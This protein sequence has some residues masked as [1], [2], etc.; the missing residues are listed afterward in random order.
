MK[1]ITFTITDDDQEILDGIRSFALA[2][3]WQEK[4]ENPDYDPEVEGSLQEIDNPV[5]DAE[6][7]NDRLWDFV[8][9]TIIAYNAQ[10]G[11]EAGRSQA[12]AAT[13]SQLANTSYNLTVE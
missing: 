12:I 2:T 5:T 7:G 11:A 10:A 8:K 1:T 4:V 3:G 9:Q 13:E 6:H